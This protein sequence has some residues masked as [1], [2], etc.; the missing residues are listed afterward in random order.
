MSIRDKIF[1]VLQVDPAAGA[2]EHEGRW[3]TW[4]QLQGIVT[5]IGRL[6]DAAG[7]PPG[8]PIGLLC[9]NSP[10]YV[11]A[12]TGVICSHRCL[13]P[14][15]PF[16]SAAR[17]CADLAELDLPVLIASASDWK[18]PELLALAHERQFMGIV[19]DGEKVHCH[20]GLNRPG[21]RKFRQPMP[22]VSIEMLSS[23][24]TGKP[25]RIKLTA[26]NLEKALAGKGKIIGGKPV[27]ARSA[28]L[29]SAPLVHISGIFWVLSHLAEGRASALLDRFSVEAWVGAVKRH[30]LRYA[31]LV[32]TGIKML[33]D[34]NI[35][36]EDL[37]SL[38]AVRSGTAPLPVALQQQF[39]ARYGVPVLNQ[40]GATEFAGAVIGWTLEQRNQYADTKPGSVGKPFPGVEV[41]IVQAGNDKAVDVGEVGLLCVKAPQLGGKEWVR[42]TDLASMDGEGFVWIRGRADNAIIR[43]GF[44]IA[45]SEVVAILEQH[46][47]ILH[48]SVVGLA[49]ERLGQVP[50]AAVQLR[51]GAEA[52]TGEELKRWAKEKMTSYFVPVDIKVVDAL[53][54][55]P[56]MKVSEP[57]VKAL[58]NA[59]EIQAA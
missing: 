51:P 46:P 4:G 13:V 31:G 44:K 43:G 12:L 34:A 21:P 53:P 19:L 30:G 29:V 14:I 47:Q 55:T 23:G 5:G 42:T 52:V 25:K 22:D 57:D 2:V 38:V 36:K 32:P 41:R 37:A 11:G 56:S 6:L 39:E 27:L 28:G 48:A 50:V 15:N 54:R 17:F 58:F 3:Y 33:L 24:T 10:E 20:P 59:S 18:A 8:S 1:P 45:P 9:R 26:A 49:H 16:T 35:P 7:L 40:Y